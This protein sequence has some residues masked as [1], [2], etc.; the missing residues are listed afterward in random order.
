MDDL[1]QVIVDS[2]LDQQHTLHIDYLSKGDV[3]LTANILKKYLRELREPLIPFELYEAFLKAGVNSN[4]AIPVTPTTVFSLAS[5]KEDSVEH[6]IASVLKAACDQLSP[7]RH[8][9]LGM[10]CELWWKVASNHT[11][12]RMTPHN[13]SIV[14]QPNILYSRTRTPQEVMA[15]MKHEHR[16][17]SDLIVFYEIIFVKSTSTVDT[18]V[19]DEGSSTEKNTEIGR[20]HV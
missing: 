13:I 5:S 9:L 4:G 20:A 14:V 16:V 1:W 15:N 10:L 18:D 3:N 19:S 6:S 8:K 2:P 7:A 17:I 12:N 11:V